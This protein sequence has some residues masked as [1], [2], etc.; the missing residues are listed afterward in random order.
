[1]FIGRRTASKNRSQKAMPYG[2]PDPIYS[3][4]IIQIKQFLLR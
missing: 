1:V 3:Y 4:A 2:K